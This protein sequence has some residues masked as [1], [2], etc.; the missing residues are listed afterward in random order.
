MNLQVLV[1]LT[2]AVNVQLHIS[3]NG[4]SDSEVE[5]M[6]EKA[7]NTSVHVSFQNPVNTPVK[8]VLIKLNFLQSRMNIILFFILFSFHKI[9]QVSHFKLVFPKQ[10]FL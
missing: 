6:V 7:H 9:P 3:Y 1:E 10:E 8:V 5:V 2:D 4:M